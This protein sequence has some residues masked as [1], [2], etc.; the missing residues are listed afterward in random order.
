MS[1]G[2][3]AKNGT[4]VCALLTVQ[5]LLA[6]SAFHTLEP[7]LEPDAAS[8]D[9]ASPDAG[10]DGGHDAQ[11]YLH[12][13][14]GAEDYAALAGKG[15]EVKYLA[16]V[17]GRTPAA[18]LDAACTFQNTREF[19][20]H[21]QFLRS[22]SA[23]QELDY[24]SY[25]S[26]V[27]RRKSRI[28]WGG[29]LKVFAGTVHPISQARG[30]LSFTAYQEGGGE[31]NL[32]HAEIRALFEQLTACTPYARELLVFVPDGG[33]Q[34]AHVRSLRAALL[35]DGVPVLLP[36]DLNDGLGAQIYSEGESY[37][38]L[39]R[40]PRGEFL[41]RYGPRDVVLVQSAPSDISLVS[42]LIT[43]HPQSEHSHVNLR[44]RE[45]GI[46]N[47]QLPEVY[48]NALLASFQGALVHL[49]AK[50][51]SVSILPARLEDAEAFWKARTPS[52]PTPQA[53]LS[54]TRL[55][56]FS[57]LRA[58]QAKAY[59]TKT[60]NLGELFFILPAAHRSQG[61]GIPFSQ[62]QRFM[63]AAQLGSV[64]HDLLEDPAAK[65]DAVLRARH[66]KTLR[67]AIKD[68]SLTADFTSALETQIRALWGEAGL[69]MRLKFRSSTN[70][71]DLESVSSAGL[72]DSK[73]GCLADDL[74]ADAQGP[75]LCL[76]AA[77][78]A[79]LEA[80]LAA[81]RTELSA[82]PERSWLAPSIADLEAELSQEKSAYAAIR[83]VW[84]S[85]WTERAFEERAY[86]GL[87]QR[88]VY[89]GIAVNP[90]FTREEL[91]SVA[92]TNL[93][94]EQG[95]LYRVVTQTA[96]IGVVSPLDPSATPETLI[97][98]RGADDKP[99]ALKLQVPSSQKPGTGS[100]WSDAELD[101]LSGLLFKLQDHFQANVYPALAP[102]S[103]DLEIKRSHEQKIVVKQARPYRRSL[104]P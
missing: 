13:L 51:G 80:E 41:E 24:D 65:T 19:G 3:K 49:V 101:T 98:Y 8:A 94:S 56:S 99:A 25:L 104:G 86:Y 77:D 37:G 14:E 26:L 82:H 11:S 88:K 95:S 5:L 12:R 47:A 53:D 50:N 96:D 34:V 29:G 57:S 97:F 4:Q 84:A 68:A 60:A 43:E 100:L 2:P 59:G 91:D 7:Q 103:L 22:F 32:T 17:E 21:V 71:E 48:E 6:C 89:M 73:S 78:R 35:A 55:L 61:F 44:L 92:M 72:Y 30:I 58:T 87:D 67:D 10:T 64:L 27:L 90:A 70:A 31:E 85:L 83:K 54:E 18:P 42:G 102:L 75:S 93:P 23:Y 36:E 81:Q 63:E 74:D 28:W 46:P 39:R 52:L 69:K 1:N 40:L 20:F 15:F 66:L 9:A 76:N 79:A 16:A 33:A 38:Y 62:Y 45:K